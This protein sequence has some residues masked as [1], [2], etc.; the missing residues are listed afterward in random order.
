MAL[1][2][3]EMLNF[4]YLQDLHGIRSLLRAGESPDAQDKDGR[5]AIM[6]AVLA[7][8]PNTQIIALLIEAGA[9]VNV[10]DRGQQWAALAFASRDRS[11]AICDLLLKAGAEIDATDAFGNTALWRAVMANNEE[12]AAL[13]LLSG[14]NPECKNN[15]GVT[16]R[17]LSETLGRK[18]P[19]V[20]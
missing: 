10:K 6:H 4:V 11:A 9:N 18:L 14:A 1:L 13:L 3:K 16:P 2:S 19:N 20:G 12:T 17:S 8:Q 7:S 5:T 15:S